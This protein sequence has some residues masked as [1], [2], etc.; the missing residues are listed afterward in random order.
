MTKLKAKTKQENKSNTSEL[1]LYSLLWWYIRTQKPCFLI[2]LFLC[3]TQRRREWH[4]GD[5]NYEIS[6]II[7]N[8]D[9]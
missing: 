8:L 4:D 7:E 9:W 6:L 5:E 3:K 1:E 2:Q